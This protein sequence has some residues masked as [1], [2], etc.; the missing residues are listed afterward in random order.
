MVKFKSADFKI[1]C[2]A[3][4]SGKI[5]M[6]NTAE[7]GKSAYSKMPSCSAELAGKIVMTNTAEKGKSADFKIPCSAELSG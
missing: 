7:K 2:S 1:P 6:T 3:E 4:L 5:V